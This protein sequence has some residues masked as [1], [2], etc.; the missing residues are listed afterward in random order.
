MIP[1][2]SHYCLVKL[3]SSSTLNSSTLP[4]LSM[5]LMS[6]IPTALALIPYVLALATEIFC[7]FPVLANHT[8]EREP[9]AKMAS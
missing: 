2:N 8:S 9:P 6:L 4:V 5:D 7:S 3:S 1:S